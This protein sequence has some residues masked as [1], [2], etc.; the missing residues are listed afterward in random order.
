[1]D[2]LDADS[3]GRPH[4]PPWNSVEPS[5]SV[6]ELH[7]HQVEWGAQLHMSQIFTLGELVAEGVF[8]PKG[9]TIAD[10]KHVTRE[11]SLQTLPGAL[12]T[13]RACILAGKG[14]RGRLGMAKEGVRGMA[15]W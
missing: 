11:A 14:Q 9:K 8:H 4:Q 3:A 6:S 5:A 7:Q 12:I 13:P 2:I 15:E 10:R 1:M